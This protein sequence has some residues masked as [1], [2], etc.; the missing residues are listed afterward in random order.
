MKGAKD[1]VHDEYC[2]GSIGKDFERGTTSS[3]R[4][5]ERIIAHR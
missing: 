4:E 5:V 2:R 3:R 1:A